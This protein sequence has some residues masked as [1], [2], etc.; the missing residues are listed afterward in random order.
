MAKREVLQ[1]SKYKYLE[2]FVRDVANVNK[3]CRYSNLAVHSVPSPGLW[4]VRGKNPSAL[5]DI[6]AYAGMPTLFMFPPP[7]HPIER[8]MANRGYGGVC[9]GDFDAV[10]MD[11]I[12]AYRQDGNVSRFCAIAESVLFI[13][14]KTVKVIFHLFS[15]VLPNGGYWLAV[16]RVEE[17]RR[18]AFE[19]LG[20]SAT[21]AGSVVDQTW[22]MGVNSGLYYPTFW[23][24]CEG[25]EL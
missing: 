25:Y 16:D 6:P 21:D 1:V 22:G 5:K 9:T 3:S 11:A 8:V 2:A 15:P 20:F 14:R 7:Y 13:P 17:D 24:E 19:R 23:P 12:A 18:W 10:K 4:F